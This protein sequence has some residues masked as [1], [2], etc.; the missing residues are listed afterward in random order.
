LI[1]C[2]IPRFSPAAQRVER[3]DKDPNWDAHN[4]RQAAA[5]EIKQDFGYST[6][7]NAGGKEGEIGGVITPAAEPAYYARKIPPKGFD[8][9][10]S[11]SGTFAIAD[12]PVHVLVGFF[13]ADTLNEWRTPNTIALR[14]QGR[15]DFFYAYVEYC[16]SRW[17][18]GGDSPTPFPTARDP[19]TGREQFI[20]FPSKGA[21]HKWSLR[22]DPKANNGGGAVIAT[23]DDKT[24]VCNLDAGHKADGATFNRF[25]LLNVM[26]SADSSGQAWL[27]DLM[28]LGERESFDADPKWDA[29]GNRRT[30]TTT[31]IRPRFDFGFSP[32]RHAGGIAAGEL[33]GLFFRGDCRYPDKI[34]WYGDRLSVLTAN[35]PLKAS[36]KIA[37]RRGVSDSSTLLGFFH[38][39]DSTTV[40]DS[41]SASI[42][43]NFLG[44]AIEGPSREGFLVY[45]AFRGLT[46]QLTADGADRPHILPDG[47][48][49]DWSLAYSPPEA[50]GKAR[51]IVTFDKRSVT[52]QVP[53]SYTRDARFD[54][55]GLMTP[56]IDGNAQR[57][58]FDDL[59]YTF[60]Q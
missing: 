45:P 54:R 36:G 18:A 43:K 25:G 56:W 23:I 39:T 49:H 46:D 53:E 15:G 1:L 11:A 33:G 37:L 50:G 20:G 13:N 7:A 4:N 24:A 52:L 48:S 9:E 55:F 42:P 16:T 10:L 28:V 6:T 51:M 60:E 32:T 41:Q 57:I 12:G 40:N 47:A 31:D 29:S 35:K 8:D 30:Y 59:D 34:A 27:D 19:R 22:Y 3:F 44:I 5:R 14:L 26:K 17:R 21:V 38:S 58:Y 2:L